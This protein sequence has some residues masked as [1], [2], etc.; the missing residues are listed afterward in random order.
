M[1]LLTKTTLNLL[2]IS[3]FIFLFGVV[4][5]YYSLRI[6]VNRNINQ[7][8]EKRKL[9]IISELESAHSANKPPVNQNEIVLISPLDQVKPRDSYSDTLIYNQAEK[10]YQIFRQKGFVQKIDN[11][12]YY[13]QIFKSLEETDNLIVRIVI[14]MTIMVFMLII[15]LLVVNRYSSRRVWSVF[16]DTVAKITR[17]DLN[18]HEEFSLEKSDVSEFDDLN[19]VLQAMTVRIKNDYLNLKEYTENASHEIQTPLAI[20]SSKLELLLQSGE[21]NEKQ[22]K[23]LADAYEASI[24]LSRYNKTLILLA[25]IENKQFPESQ[26]VSPEIIIEHQLENLDDLIRDKKIEIIKRIQTGVNIQMN[27][28]LAEMLIVNL[29]KNAVRHNI[30]NGKLIIE[31]NDR[32]LK[33]ANTGSAGQLDT[34]LLFNRFY[35][36]SS[37]PESLGLGLAIVQKICSLYGFTIHYS[38]EDE[39]HCM[40]INHKVNTDSL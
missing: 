6:Q 22:Y 30:T 10:R 34:N 5:F 11:R 16:Y 1:R 3:L 35:K 33:I 23:A 37:S 39:M 14:I 2:S 8:M 24:R 18:S 26:T 7:E 31:V 25:K 27:P 15:A 40:Q 13:I 28:Y 9:S 12:E 20:I 4:A 29:I 21:M 19:R 17:Y 38:Y 36:S 32:F